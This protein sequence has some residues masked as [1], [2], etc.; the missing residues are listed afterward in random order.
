MSEHVTIILHKVRV[1]GLDAYPGSEVF[2]ARMTSTIDSNAVLHTKLE[3]VE[4][5]KF[6]RSECWRWLLYWLIGA[7]WS[8]LN[9]KIG[10][11]PVKE[12]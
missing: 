11:W 5:P 9:F 1:F 10:R 4:Q 2:H 8:W 6:V 12:R 3:S 7:P